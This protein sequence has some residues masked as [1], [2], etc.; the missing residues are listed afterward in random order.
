MILQ[1]LAFAV[2]V[3]FSYFVFKTARDYGRNPALWTILTVGVGLGFQFIL[4]FVVGIILAIVWL[5]SGTPAER[6]Q[7]ELETH[8]ILVGFVSLGLSFVGMFLILKYV[9]R[10]P[11]ESPIDDTPPPPPT[12]EG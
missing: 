3:V 2:L 1:I 4:P 11:D 5:A 6:L 10:L 9:S 7:T 8:L 12:F